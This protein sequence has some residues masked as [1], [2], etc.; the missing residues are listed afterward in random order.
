MLGRSRPTVNQPCHDPECRVSLLPERIQA[1][2]GTPRERG[3]WTGAALEGVRDLI[4][5][6]EGR[7]E[8]LEWNRVPG[9]RLA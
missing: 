3:S 6:Y 9:P 5:S 1:H 4:P 7:A 8:P 2:I